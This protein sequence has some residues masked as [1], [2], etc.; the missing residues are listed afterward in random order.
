MDLPQENTARQSR[1][2]TDDNLLLHLQQK[3]ARRPAIRFMAGP[4][5]KN[6]Q[7][8]IL[9]AH[10]DSD[11]LQCMERKATPHPG[12]LPDRGGEGVDF[13]PFAYSA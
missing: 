9:A 4:G 2:Q 12:P 11:G 1:N 3:V 13:V 5:R 10:V 6:A 8:K 7:Q